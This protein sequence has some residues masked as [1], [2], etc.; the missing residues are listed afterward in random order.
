MI[1]SYQGGG[2]NASSAPAEMADCQTTSST[3]TASA[4]MAESETIGSARGGAADASSVV[5]GRTDNDLS[6]ASTC[7]TN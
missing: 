2:V 7:G 3:R 6:T 4:R 5:A 1:G